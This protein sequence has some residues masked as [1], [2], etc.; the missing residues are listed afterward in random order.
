[1]VLLLII[2]HCTQI[3]LAGADASALLEIN[4]HLVMG[5][6][7]IGEFVAREV[8]NVEICVRAAL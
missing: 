8:L 5:V 1:M 6:A 2:V 7:T 3:P 4:R